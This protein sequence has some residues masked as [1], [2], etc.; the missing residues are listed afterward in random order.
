MR[1]ILKYTSENTQESGFCPHLVRGNLQRPFKIKRTCAQSWVLCSIRR[2]RSWWTWVWNVFTE[3][4][5]LAYPWSLL[6]TCTVPVNHKV[7]PLWAQ[8]VERASC[9][10]T[11]PV[12]AANL[13]ARHGDSWLLVVG[14]VSSSPQIPSQLLA[15]A[16]EAN[17]HSK[18]QGTGV[19]VGSVGVPLCHCP[20]ICS[21]GTGSIWFQEVPSHK[22]RDK[23]MFVSL[24]IWS[25]NFSDPWQCWARGWTRQE[26]LWLKQSDMK[27]PEIPMVV[28]QRLKDLQVH[29]H[30]GAMCGQL[31][32]H[33]HQSP[34]DE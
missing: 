11:I 1:N 29:G 16:S 8:Q 13:H 10:I 9:A 31:G 4:D 26:T 27:V 30:L 24:A 28:L 12:I 20:G 33:L 7:I 6:R 5:K 2:L 23:M 34:C 18:A 17:I 14:G 22:V 3:P 25:C 19:D 21:C 15:S 32:Q